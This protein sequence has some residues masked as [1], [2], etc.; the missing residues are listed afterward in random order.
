M[1]KIL[2]WITELIS[3]YFSLIFCQKVWNLLQMKVIHQSMDMLIRYIIRQ[4]QMQQ[5]FIL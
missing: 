5:V 1:V 3:W 4:I 2:L